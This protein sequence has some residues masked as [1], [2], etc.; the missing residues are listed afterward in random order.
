MMNFCILAMFL[1]E[2][3]CFRELLF[4]L[5][6]FSYLFSYQFIWREYMGFKCSLQISDFIYIYIYFFFLFLCY[7]EHIHSLDI[8]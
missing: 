3:G 7:V 4:Y 8:L 5:P 2:L 6:R 1:Y